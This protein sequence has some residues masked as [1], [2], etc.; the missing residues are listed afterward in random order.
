MIQKLILLN[1]Q[2]QIG[3]REVADLIPVLK[4]RMGGNNYYLGMMTFQDL[5]A[6]V[7][8][9]HEIR[10]DAELGE[11]LQREIKKR[12]KDMVQYLLKQKERFYGS[13]I[14]AAFGGNP[15]FVKVQ[16]EDHPLLNDD[17]NYGLLKF[18]SKQEYFALDGQH[19]LSSIKDAIQ[20][21]PKLKKEEISVIILTHEDTPEGTIHTR[22]LF[23]TL[24]RYAKPTT[25]GENIA[26]DEDNVVSIAT[27]MLLKAYKLFSPEHMEYEKKNISK[28]KKDMKKF[29]SLAALYNFNYYVLHAIYGFDSEYL[30]FRPSSGDVEQM[31]CT[32]KDLWGE[33]INKFDFLQDIE[34]NVYD[35]IH[36]REPKGGSSKDSDPAKGKLLLRPIGLEI[37]GKL[38][39]LAYK[40]KFKD[41]NGPVSKTEWKKVVDMIEKLPLI[42]GKPPWKGTIFRNNKM[43]PGASGLA[44]KIGSYML[45]LGKIDKGDLT[46]EYR[47]HLE[48]LKATLPKKLS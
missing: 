26:L 11:K 48:D 30:R 31:F 27:R 41:K 32:I 13:L 15:E 8:F 43:E 42:L 22:R 37:Y 16:M 21:D 2:K 5:A 23:H 9:F 4:G 45:G 36:Y 17:F 44:Y 25:T 19:R 46:K 39:A 12:S 35:A 20:K 6:K 34:G 47:G 33:I 18:N 1:L 38:I 14:I 24:N 3:G 28:S 10:P 40:D 29:T 7:S